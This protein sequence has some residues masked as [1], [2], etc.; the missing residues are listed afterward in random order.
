MTK[1]TNPPLITETAFE[2]PHCGAYTTQYWFDLYANPREKNSTPNIP[3]KESIKHIL[4]DRETPEEVK[5]NFLRWVDR[6]ALGLV[7][8]QKMSDS[9]YVYNDVENL[10]LSKCYNCNKVAVWVHNS[11][12]FP[13]EK[14]GI[15]PNQDLPE[16]IIHDFEEARSIIGESPRGAAALLRLCVQKLCVHLGEKGKNLDD[17]IASLVSKGL[18]PLVKKSLDIVRVIGNEAVHPGVIDLNDNREIANQLLGLINSIATQM[19]SHPKNIEKLY[20]ELPPSKREAIEKRDKKL[21]K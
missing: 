19:I 16:D 20:Q 18:N 11:L 9:K 5:Q 1:K 13:R 15:S 12:L 3:K 7:L 6:L 2:C 21:N 4:E 17:D 8:I 10:H 14:T